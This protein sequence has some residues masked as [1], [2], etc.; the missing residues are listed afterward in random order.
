MSYQAAANEFCAQIEGKRGEG[1]DW[2]VDT[3]RRSGQHVARVASRCA[4]IVGCCMG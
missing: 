1:G 3:A 4:S 2:D